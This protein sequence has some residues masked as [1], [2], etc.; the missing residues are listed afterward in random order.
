MPH[1]RVIC[2]QPPHVFSSVCPTYD[3]AL[4]VKFFYT[5][6][7]IIRPMNDVCLAICPSVGTLGH[8]LYGRDLSRDFFPVTCWNN[9]NSSCSKGIS[10]KAYFRTLI[11]W[12]CTIEILAIAWLILFLLWHDMEWTYIKAVL[13]RTIVESSHKYLFDG[14]VRY[15]SQLSLDKFG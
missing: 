13:R 9:I 7:E 6:N 14:V 1:I 11:W 2:P 4:K 10:N 12:S 8:S 3:W 15:I 5:S